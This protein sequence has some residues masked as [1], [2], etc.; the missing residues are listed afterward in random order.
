MS[1]RKKQKEETL[2]DILRVAEELF[3][4]KG[5]EK[6]TIVN[7]ADRCGLSKGAL[8]HHFK[9]KEEVLERICFKN[10][11][12]QKKLFFPI[13]RDDN[14]TMSEKLQQI[15]IMISTSQ[16]NPAATSFGK[17]TTVIK[18]GIE[19]ASM[20]KLNK[21]YRTRIY[22]EVLAPLLEQGRARGEIA[23]P[24]SAEVM[25]LYIHHLDRGMGYQLNRIILADDS[26]NAK[27]QIIDVVRGFTFAL[28][29][30]LAV[31]EPTVA[32]VTLADRMM[33]QYLQL[34]NQQ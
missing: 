18:N 24:G 19:N 2:V 16:M 32:D 17:R 12:E 11:L 34:L 31:D 9:C 20:S 4:E 1:K 5:Y 15:M 25:S 27:E 29:R 7:I 26:I 14:R 10:Y 6:T 30:L 8:Y 33:E 22:I 3:S 13:V 28:S 21:K 23:F